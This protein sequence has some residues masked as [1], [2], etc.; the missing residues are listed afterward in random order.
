MVAKRDL[1]EKQGKKMVQ[2]LSKTI[3]NL[4]YGGNIRRDNIDQL[5]YVKKNWMRENYGDRVKEW[6]LLKNGNS[7]VK[8]EHDAGV[9]DQDLAK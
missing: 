1:H 2:T 3:F 6:W 8:F 7:I 9:G 4:V 5:K